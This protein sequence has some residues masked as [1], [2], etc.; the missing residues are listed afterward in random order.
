MPKDCGCDKESPK[1]NQ[2]WVYEKKCDNILNIPDNSYVGKIG[3]AYYLVNKDKKER[4][5]Y[6][7]DY[8]FSNLVPNEIDYYVSLYKVTKITY[9]KKTNNLKKYLEC[10]R[11]YSYKTKVDQTR[12]VDIINKIGND[13][14]DLIPDDSNKFN[15]IVIKNILK[16]NTKKN[17]ESGLTVIISQVGK[18]Y[19]SQGCNA[20][21]ENFESCVSSCPNC[22]EKSGGTFGQVICQ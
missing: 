8:K 12:I 11:Q 21:C 15:G 4:T 18:M 10:V 20:S 13:D 3:F 19:G 7:V 22:V 1:R 14:Y 9:H 5:E 6:K 17:T 2:I 16:T